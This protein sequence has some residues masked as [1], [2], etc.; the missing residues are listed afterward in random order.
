MLFVLFSFISLKAK[1]NRIGATQLL[2]KESSIID[3]TLDQSRLSSYLYFSNI[4][5]NFTYIST[6][7]SEKIYLEDKYMFISNEDVSLYVENPDSPINLTIWIIPSD[8]CSNNARIFKAN[9]AIFSHWVFT[10][11]LE[12]ICFFPVNKAKAEVDIT[13]FT[14]NKLPVKSNLLVYTS[15]DSGSINVMQNLTKS[16]KINSFN[17]PFFISLKNAGVG[18]IFAYEIHFSQEIDDVCI[19]EP[20]LSLNSTNSSFISAFSYAD[21]PSFACSNEH[22]NIMIKRLIFG[23]ILMLAAVVLIL[24]AFILRAYFHN[25]KIAKK[26]EKRKAK[27]NILN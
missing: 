8:I 10:E 15:D 7:K 22:D 20:F 11:G 26:K 3:V 2:I 9:Q 25:R 19:N 18:T 27:N 24:L 13:L 16:K 17:K 14:P 5:P 12:K 4:P 6:K 21:E 23:L 1:V